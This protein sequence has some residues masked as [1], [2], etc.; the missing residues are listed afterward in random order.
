MRNND[1]TRIVRQLILNTSFINNLGIL[2]GK[3]GVAIFFYHYFLYTKD[4]KY[5]RFANFLLDEIYE[6]IT[7]DLCSDFENGL[8]GIGWGIEYL[9]Q[10]GFVKGNTNEVLADIDSLV[11]ERDIR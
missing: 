6:D 4:S 10:N 3:M 8:S 1:L 11:F 9:I 2:N 7:I 5:R